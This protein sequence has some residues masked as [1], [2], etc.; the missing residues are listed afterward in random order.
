MFLHEIQPAKSTA[1]Q[2]VDQPYISEV[3]AVVAGI[4][5][6]VTFNESGIEL[7]GWHAEV[8]CPLMQRLKNAHLRADMMLKWGDVFIVRLDMTTEP[9][10]SILSVT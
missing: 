6:K 2:A 4:C 10:K 1:T 8:I 5:C 3:G 9:V 7:D